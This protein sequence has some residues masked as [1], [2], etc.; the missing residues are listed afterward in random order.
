LTSSSASSSS[1]TSG[2]VSLVSTS[3]IGWSSITSPCPSGVSG[4]T[5]FISGAS[6]GSGA[7]ATIGVGGVTGPVTLGLGLLNSFSDAISLIKVN[8]TFKPNQ[9]N[10]AIYDMLF[11]EYVQIFK[12]NKEMYRNLNLET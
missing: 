3:S 6:S 1:S 5:G 9:E 12:R 11:N 7:L 2:G 8:K 10:R 4:V